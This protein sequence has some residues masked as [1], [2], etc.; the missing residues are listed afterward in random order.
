MRR[1]AFA[2]LSILCL[3]GAAGDPATDVAVSAEAAQALKLV[4]DPVEGARSY[5]RC[6]VC[7]GP[8]GEG[9]SDGTFPALA[10]QH[11]SVIIKQL[12]DIR[13]GRRRNPVMEPHAREL[14][15][16]QEGTALETGSR[17]Y[18]RDCLA[19]H[20]AAGQGD[21]E[22]FVPVVAGQHYAYLLRQIRA[23]AGARQRGAHA[24]MAR[25]VAGY[26]D[27]ELQAVADYAS[28]MGRPGPESKA[29]V[30]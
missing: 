24:A 14:I 30:P 23:I 26:R 18:Q 17:L 1:A 9:R 2:L 5:V 12:V 19:C 22:R 10:G 11:P 4:G 25:I 15:G 3:T 16:P 7:H 27:A 21:A 8:R 6:A 20:G 13:E 28:R 29:E